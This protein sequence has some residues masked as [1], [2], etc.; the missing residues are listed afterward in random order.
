MPQRCTEMSP[1]GRTI[2]IPTYQDV[3]GVWEETHRN[4]G[5]TY[6]SMQMWP[7]NPTGLRWA[8]G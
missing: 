4:M 6:K 7:V 3:F 8:P 1:L 2:Y 5:R